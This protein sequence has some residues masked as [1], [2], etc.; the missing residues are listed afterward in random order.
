[1]NRLL[2]RFAARSETWQIIFGKLFMA[3]CSWQVV[4]GKLFMESCTG[5]TAQPN[6]RLPS[7][8]SALI[9]GP[10]SNI[11]D[12]LVGRIKHLVRQRPLHSGSPRNFAEAS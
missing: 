4:H 10:R 2:V 5:A 7:I 9:V 8:T 6:A 11:K 3:S 1:L 12:D